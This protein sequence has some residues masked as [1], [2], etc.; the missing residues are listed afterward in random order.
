MVKI[1]YFWIAIIGLGQ[2]NHGE[3]KNVGYETL[4][5]ILRARRPK[6]LKKGPNFK[7]IIS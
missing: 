3:S 1:N 5:S 7:V 2:F 4:G 6:T